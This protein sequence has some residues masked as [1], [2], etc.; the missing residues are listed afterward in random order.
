MNRMQ[1]YAQLVRLPNLPSALADIFLG[2]LVTGSLTVPGRWPAYGL[3]MLASVCLYCGGMAWNDFF[4][5]EQDRRERPDRPIP[6]GRITPFHAAVLAA[7]LVAVGV[8]F[9]FLAGLVQAWRG[10]GGVVTPTVLAL[11]LTGAIFLYDAWLKHT[12][13]GPVGMG[14]C[15]FLNV[16]LGITPV[17]GLLW[18]RGL[19]L[20][21]VV[22][23]YIVGVTWLARTEAR[24]SSRRALIGAASVMLLSLLMVLPLPVLP[25]PVVPPADAS[26]LL[27]PYLLVGLG[28]FVGFPVVAAIRAPTPGRVQSAVK[29]SLMGLILLDMVLATALAGSAGL[30]L[31]VLMAPSVYLNRRKWLYAT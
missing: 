1:A 28:F 20:A 6:S 15:R 18:S 13:V 5:L 30:V 8:A 26:S 25:L 11:L 29:R 22:G 16:L 27:F 19:Y 2:V 24:A 17:A 9:A 10:E 12:V 21:L 31:L 7:G 4:D 23:L 3:L 14:M